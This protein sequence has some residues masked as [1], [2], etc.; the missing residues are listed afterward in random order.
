MKCFQVHTL[1]S[2]KVLPYKQV[3]NN[4]YVYI[5]TMLRGRTRDRIYK[6]PIQRHLSCSVSLIAV[7]LYIYTYLY[8]ILLSLLFCFFNLVVKKKMLQSRVYGFITVIIDRRTTYFVIHLPTINLK[9]I[10]IILLQV[11]AFFLFFSLRLSE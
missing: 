1:I 5:H 8:D 9:T 3:Q 10:K 2:T 7:Y 6:N 4:I 11:P